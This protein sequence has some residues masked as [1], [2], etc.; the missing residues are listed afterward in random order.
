MRPTGWPDPRPE[1]RRP[2]WKILVSFVAAIA[3]IALIVTIA[4]RVVPIILHR[5]PRHLRRSPFIL[6]GEFLLLMLL[7]PPIVLVHELGHAIAGTLAGWRLQSL[8]VGP[9]RFIRGHRNRIVLHRSYFYY[10]GAAVVVPGEWASDERIRRSFRAMVAGGPFASLITSGFLF[11]VVLFFAPASSPGFAFSGGWRF[12]IFVGAA[13]SLA[14]GFGTLVPIRQASAVRNDGL[15]LLLSRPR[16]RNGPRPLDPMIRLGALV[17]MLTERRPREWTP[18]MLAILAASPPYQ[19]QTF[20]YYHA[21]DRG[22]LDRARGIL[23]SMADR[24]VSAE[25]ALGLRSR[26]EVA[27]E[28]AIFEAAFRGDGAA[29][30]NWLALSGD[31]AR[32]DPHIAG[33]ARAATS[34]ALGDLAA[35]RIAMARAAR[36]ADQRLIARVDLLRA[37]LIERIVQ[38]LA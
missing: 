10:G 12:V 1:P 15:Q 22:E 14:I 17:L 21:L 2:V 5:P 26:Q 24:V 25:G 4:G 3:A 20:E 13:M 37:P 18:E 8:F 7:F 9:W 16:D 23:Q 38:A 30:E 29:A 35:G 32:W 6:A 28:A 31:A 33:L 27:L 19:R 11:A 34:A 36:D